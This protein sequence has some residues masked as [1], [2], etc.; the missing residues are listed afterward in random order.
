MAYAPDAGGAGGTSGSGS[1]GTDGP[2]N[3]GSG[4]LPDGAGIGDACSDTVPCRPGLSCTDDVCEPGHSLGPGEACVI[5][6]ECEEGLQCIAGA[7]APAGDGDVGDSCT[8][9]ASCKSGLRCDGLL[10]KTCVAAGDGD[11][12]DSCTVNVDCFAGL[13][14]KEGM[15]APGTGF[16]GGT[17]W[18]GV[19]CGDVDG[20]V[21]AYFEVPGAEDAEEL[22]FFRLPFP[23]DV[24]IKNG[25][26]DLEGF[27]TPGKG[28]VGVDLVQ[29]YVD[30]IEANDSGFGAYPATFFRF[31][32][33]L[34]VDSL[35]ADGSVNLVDIT[36]GS[37]EYGTTPGLN[38]YYSVGRSPYI[39]DNWIAVRP[40]LGAS[41][42]PGHT[43]AVWLTTTIT[44]EDGDDV[45]KAPNLLSLLAG[46]A[47]DDAALEDGYDAYGIFRD[48]L[49]DRS[50]N[51]GTI[52]N[53]AV[54]TVAQVRDTMADLAAAIEELD[55]PSAKDWVKC[56]DGAE[57]PC[58]NG[59]AGRAC[60]TNADFDEYHALVSLPIF[61]EGTAPYETSGG[62]IAVTD[63]PERQDVCLSLTV[64]KGDMPVEGWPIVVFAHGTGGG[65]RS[66]V[67]PEVAGV[68]STAS[69]PFAVLGIDQVVHGPR[70]GD[71]TEDP[72]NLF[73]NIF[74][75]DAARG[76][77]MQGAADQLSLAK[78]AA[79]LD[80]SAEESGGE[81]IKVDSAKIFYFGHSQGSTE[82]SLALPFSN[83][84]KAAV[85]SGNG[86]SL[87]D[88]L[89]TK[90]EPVD[91]KQVVPVVLS[92]PSVAEVKTLHPVLNLLQEWIDPSDPINYAL[93]LTRQPIGAYSPKHAFQTY[94]F[95]DSY[96]P[97]VTMQIYALAGIIP[98]VAPQTEDLELPDVDSP[99][100]GNVDVN[101]NAY[102][103]G[104]RQ[105]EPPSG[106]D[107]HF[108]VF[109]VEQANEDMVRFF[110]T[111]AT[112]TPVIGD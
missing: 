47:P 71:S 84:Y 88:A 2:G 36:P 74:N 61:Q 79:S 83:L 97:E 15:C 91:I 23:N 13:D 48:Y 22:D 75:P 108:V 70:R 28:L 99:A 103:L 53:A 57:S 76:N 85:L 93:P 11:V 78:F 8:S 31:S 34:D 30:A 72:E 26:V 60:E 37:D 87:M 86:A 42:V 69:T 56:E 6:P 95:D 21:R 106:S 111:A 58:E 43:Y 25:A 20:P 107:G 109:D 92:D 68:L 59:V 64:P 50:I 3:G 62:A 44:T 52:L 65:F 63:D 40:S 51:P 96:S 46:S 19:E 12:G 98:H 94:G 67:R 77:P 66:H 100:S 9:D 24:R 112:G 33:S 104:L 45:Q 102:T 27:P 81:A 4:D 54:F 38:W 80:L 7:C 105:Y 110:T 14:C 55:P 41:L 82:G 89:L 18:K 35:R 17:L 49:E 1:G 90:T 32:G 10:Q 29:R 39:C 5:G 16:P 73:F 101:G